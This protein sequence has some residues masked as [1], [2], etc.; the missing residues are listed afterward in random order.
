MIVSILLTLLVFYFRCIQ[1]VIKFFEYVYL[2]TLGIGLERIRNTTF[3]KRDLN[4]LV[5]FSI[6]DR[7]VLKPILICRILCSSS[8]LYFFGLMD[9]CNIKKELSLISK[10]QPIINLVVII[11]YKLK[12]T[13]FTVNSSYKLKFYYAVREKVRSV[14]HV[15]TLVN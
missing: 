13:F 9:L 6:Q 5:S 14:I 3:K 4:R 12:L 7:E 8:S 2:Y 1:N 11:C 15:Y 10:N